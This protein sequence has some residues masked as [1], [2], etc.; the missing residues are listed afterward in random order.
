MVAAARMVVARI[1]QIPGFIHDYIILW[2]CLDFGIRGVWVV[3][4][5]LVV[6]GRGVS[7]RLAGRGALG[8]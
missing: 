1:P 5:R 8:V 7:V 6:V 4:G 2:S 3:I